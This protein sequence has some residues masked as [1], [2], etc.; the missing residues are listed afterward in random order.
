MTIVLH[1]VALN[2]LSLGPRAS[3]PLLRFEYLAVP[4]E[5][6]IRVLLRARG[7]FPINAPRVRGLRRSR[8]SEFVEMLRQAPWRILAVSIFAQ[9]AAL[10]CIGLCPCRSLLLPGDYDLRP[11]ALP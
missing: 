5:Q 3:S 10:E 1:G 11:Y 9:F 2:L 7:R 4:A 6:L 8:I